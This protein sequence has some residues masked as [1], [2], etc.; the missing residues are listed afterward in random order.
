MK[1]RPYVIV[2]PSYCVSAGVRVM[3][4]LC[5]ELNA[6]GLDAKLLIT[7]NLS[8][9]P[10]EML[11]PALN[12]PCI[13]P[14]FER[15]WPRLQDEA[16]V[17]CTDGFPGNP[18][19]AKHVVRYVLGKEMPRETDNPEEF[20][21]YYSKAFPAQRAGR[22]AVLYLLPIDLALF[23]ANNVVERPQNMLWLG[24]GARFLKDTHEGCIPITY[25]WPPTR[26]ELAFHLRRTS[27]LYSYDAVSATNLEAVLC[28]ATVVLKHLSYHDW[29]WTRA[30]MEAMEQG[31]GGFAFGDS[32]YELD[33]AERT[34]QETMERIRYHQAS[35][36]MRLLEFVEATQYR[37]RAN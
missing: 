3:H 31:T 37:F 26:P 8:P 24:K 30:D 20:R 35:F 23:N 18:F 27:R 19:G 4:T 5:H 32:D 22:H 7:S 10:A 1:T 28:G 29:T 6:L 12:T 14:I 34:R 16:I 2:T 25:S 9:S 11:N 15:A 13:N 21:V 36:K 33:R 17:I